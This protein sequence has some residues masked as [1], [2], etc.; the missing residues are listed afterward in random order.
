[1]R[2]FK[3]YLI[4][5]SLLFLFSCSRISLL[6]I[7]LTPSEKQSSRAPTTYD[8]RQQFKQVTTHPELD[9]MPALSPDGKWI[10][11]ASKRSGNM[12]IWVKPVIG[13]RSIQVTF[14]QAD[15][16]YPCWAPN[17]K[18]IVFVSHR[19]DAA[20]D[21]WQLKIDTQ[22]DIFTTIG[23]PKKLTH[24]LGLDEAPA[25]SPSGKS[26]AF[27]SERDGERNIWLYN[28]GKKKSHQLTFRGGISPTWS[29][30]GKQ[31]AF[32]S[33]R[34]GKSS[35]GD[36]F[37]INVPSAKKH[38][39]ITQITQKVFP[40]THGTSLD[41]QPYWS[42]IEDE[43]I[44]TRYFRDTNGDGKVSPDDQSSLW[45][46][47]VP[48]TAEIQLTPYGNYDYFPFWGKDDQ[49]YYVSDKSGNRDIWSISSDGPIPRHERGFLQYQF[50]ELYF[51]LP[52]DV[53]IF[54][55][56]NTS[57]DEL[58]SLTSFKNKYDTIDREF[59]YLRLLAYQRVAD[60]F[61]GD[62]TWVGFA[63]YELA[64]TFGELNDVK[65]AAEF[66]AQ[67]L[68]TYKHR[69][70]IVGNA[71]WDLLK[72]EI[73]SHQNDF[74]YLEEKIRNCHQARNKFYFDKKLSAKFDLMIADVF[75]FM[76]QKL[77]AL[78][79]YE[80][81][82]KI[83]PEEREYCAIAQAKIAEIYTSFG[84][85]EDVIKSFLKVINNY[86]EQEKWVNE[87]IEKIL[88]L[89]KEEDAYSTIAVY[90]NII[91]KYSKDYPRLAA[92]AYL[93]IGQLLI[94]QK[95]YQAAI[96][97]LLLVKKNYP[98]QYTEIALAELLISEAYLQNSEELMAINNLKAIIKNSGHVESGLYVVIAKEQLIDIYLTSGRR[99]RNKGDFQLAY[100]RYHGVTELQPRNIEA[101]RGLVFCLSRM[102]R[103]HDAVVTY[104]QNYTQNPDDEV[105]QYIL[106]LCYSYKATEKSERERKI[107]VLDYSLIKKS[108]QIIEDALVKN[109][110]LIPAYLALSYNYEVIEKYESYQ[111]N[112]PKGFFTELTQTIAAPVVSVF[113]F[114]TFPKA[115]PS[116]RWYEKAIDALT[117][118][119]ALNDEN[120]DPSLE[121]NL[122]LNLAHNYYNLEEF[123]YEKA[124]HYYHVK[125]KYDTTFIDLKDKAE[126]Y[127]RMGHCAL[128]LEDFEKGPEYL[129]KA[130]KLYQD[131]DE[132]KQDLD[133]QVLLNI[134]RLALL[135]QSTEKIKDK[136]KREHENAIE[137]FRLAEQK[138]KDF[139]KT[140]KENRTNEIEQIYRGIAYNYQLLEDEEEALRYAE[141]AV[142]L[143][144]SK[145]LREIEAKPNWIKLSILGIEFPVWN[146]G[147][148]GAGESTAIEGFTTDEERALVYSIMANAYVQQK[149]F[150]MALKYYDKKLDIYHKRDDRVA[151][152]IFLNN[153]GYLHYKNEDYAQA[154]NYFEKSLRICKKED[155]T[156]GVLSNVINLGSLGVLFS[157]MN[158]DKIDYFSNCLTY[159]NYGLALYAE[160]ELGF[161]EEHVHLL[162]LLGNLY[163]L[164]Q[165]MLPDSIKQS[166][167]YK[168]TGYTQELEN[169]SEAL[170]FYNK[171]LKLAEDKNYQ[172][173]QVIIFQNLGQVYLSADEL[174]QSYV[175][176]NK[177]RT[178]AI[179][180]N[181]TD[182]LWRTNLAMAKL[183]SL[184][185]YDQRSN[186]KENEADFYYKEAI[187]IL[188]KST[189]GKE[190]FTPTQFYLQEIRNL[191]ES[192]IQY[193]ILSQPQYALMLSERMR[194]KEY[195]DVFNYHK[196]EL[197]REMH[198]LHLGNVR[199]DNK[200]IAE[201]DEEIRFAKLN[202]DTKKSKI[203]TLIKQRQK[204]LEEYAITLR[205]M[206]KDDDLEIES[207]VLVNP[208]SVLEIQQILPK[209]GIAINYLITKDSTYVWIITNRI[210]NF[211]I[212]PIGK[213]FLENEVHSFLSGVNN[214]QVINSAQSLYNILISPIAELI[215]QYQTIFIIPDG[216]LSFVPFNSLLKLFLNSEIPDQA[217]VIAPSL[218]DYYFRFQK[219]KISGEKILLVN[220]DS[221][222][223]YLES[224]G[225]V[226][227]FLETK[228][229]EKNIKIKQQFEDGEI[230]H[231]K[232][233]VD[234]NPADPLLT[235]I[236]TNKINP[237]V[238]KDIYA[239]DLKTSLIIINGD[240]FQHYPDEANFRCFNRTFFYAGTPT[241][242][243]SLWPVDE[244]NENKFY[245]YFYDYLLDYSPA[246]AFSLTQ[247]AMKNDGISFVDWAGYQLVG[248]QGMTDSEEKQFAAEKFIAEVEYGNNYD[249]NKDWDSAI[250]KYESALIMARKLGNN[251]H[252]NNLQ[253]FIIMAAGNGANYSK[254]IEYQLELLAEAEYNLDI[255]GMAESY[256]NLVVFYTEDK[257][258]NKAVVYQNKYIKLAEKYGLKEEAAKS[259]HKLGLINEKGGNYQKAIEYYGKSIDAYRDINNLPGVAV[260]LKDRGRIYFSKLDN[261]SLAI[262]DI[263]QALTI[264]QQ[265]GDDENTIEVFQ[266][267]GLCYE[268]I[269]DY[270]T[271]LEYQNK[272][273]QLAEEI[274]SVTQIAI[275]YQYLA[276][277]KWNLDEYQA[278]DQFQN[279]ALQQF[280][281]IGN[282]KWLL[283][284][285][286]T[287]GLIRMS[288]GQYDEGLNSESKAL[289]LAEQIDDKQDQATI[290]K[291]IGLLYKADNR[292]TQ[293][294]PEF[295]KAMEIDKEINYKRGL[296]WDY[297]NLGS[298]H[299]S[300]NKPDTSLLF[301]RQALTLSREIN[302]SRNEIKCYYE[303]GKAYFVLNK[304]KPA[305]D[306]LTL[307][308]DKAHYLLIPNVEWRALWV[309]GQ[310]YEKSDQL[311]LAVENYRKAIAVIEKMRSRIKVEELKSGFIDDKLD[312]YS[313]L[314]ML[315]LRM[316]QPGA[317]LEVVERSK[318]RNFLDMLANR[319][320]TF[321]GE[322]SDQL[323]AEGRDIQKN[324]MKIQ[325]EIANLRSKQDQL[326]VPEK[327][328]LA[329]LEEKETGLKQQYSSYLIKLKTEN[330]ELAEMIN[331]EPRNLE[332]IQK[333]L[334][335]TVALVEYYY[336]KEKIAIFVVTR[337]DVNF[338][339]I[340][341]PDSVLV[342]LV[343]DFR[344]S[345]GK[346]LSI[347]ALSLKVNNLL[348]APISDDISNVSH[349]VIV[350]HNVLHY[351][352]FA[353]LMDKGG[354][355][356]IEKHT[357][358]LAPSATVLGFCVEKGE[359]YQIDKKEEYK[360][361]AFGNPNLKTPGMALPFAE[362]E[363]AS[364][365]LTYTKVTSY[366]EQEATET[367]FKDTSSRANVILLSCHG[368]FEAENPL[369]SALLLTPDDMNDGRLEAHEIFGLDLDS[370]LTAMS[371]C[372]TGLG[373]IKGGDEVIGLSRS[374]IY[375]G[376]ASL[377]SSLWKVDDLATAVLIKRFFRY[378]KAQGHTR[379]AALREAQLIVKNEINNHPAFWAAF[380]ISG[381]FR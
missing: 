235:Q 259:Y 122:A 372:E 377:L 185:N 148:I 346:R 183:L 125:L 74:N 24:H 110:R 84:Q 1:M 35:G 2:H 341:Q 29:P 208:P 308:A 226:P 63:E 197:K 123:G 303:L 291:N 163:Y 23:K 39:T 269:A 237:I 8:S 112:K 115:K 107:S 358:S 73:K 225:Y 124:Y 344:E 353:A 16:L 323:L 230:I 92:S 167:E 98:E 140:E 90:F 245:S 57:I 145:N 295:L 343:E 118:A 296:A 320:I 326:T 7:S 146:L 56:S 158:F 62:S 286:S 139:E 307:A 131:L 33:F 260:N 246:Q 369:F 304:M 251:D 170:F 283:M 299:T 165:P 76:D 233:T 234:W 30:D 267:L 241:I 381:D 83:Y 120:K 322:A 263:T 195:I 199:H 78:D 257:N 43:I 268:K 305:L 211:K 116:E 32:V 128:V 243:Y 342:G 31:I 262:N 169:L 114:I 300:M 290:H 362:K 355:Y 41:A 46:I 12:D 176:F 28:V 155:L 227:F 55:E 161:Q 72:I 288:L 67:L 65:F 231:L 298:L 26:I 277:V 204:Y 70:K 379:A 347:D 261:Y 166:F 272:A 333:S 113:R 293:A 312:V 224:M 100:Q 340:N 86:P 366:L 210:I 95:D 357:I 216:K 213:I 61:P 133:K 274:G 160:K 52:E 134:K 335:D 108:N 180:Y 121:G 247:Q 17:G 136:D 14:H 36:I 69:K 327:T 339:T 282:K 106:G 314:I 238:I 153:I 171:A 59:L 143:L 82:I 105:A 10:T 162:I 19:E 137:Y 368:E 365:R 221:L 348:I 285:L 356:L 203:D 250:R 192:A 66:Y 354:K 181:F 271:S 188:E 270:Q 248:F 232:T 313:D 325:S 177:A 292:Q 77:S 156:A 244:Q 99:L 317:A 119:I 321:R 249:E 49:I 338:A 214:D 350:P 328:K 228:K 191:Y 316:H 201:K 21:L 361:L 349:L 18:K 147:P 93:K 103:I 38:K 47:I 37:V 222:Y 329:D 276:N 242:L 374:F 159:I 363:V 324:I 13:G 75:F 378:L 258:F 94:Q 102:K 141:Q 184:L 302:D 144:K 359:K 275:T 218:S 178:L 265:E 252:V 11:F 223:Q 301:L 206:K 254:A 200:R 205:D 209:N 150:T 186:L 53:S 51:P 164:Q 126:V 104:K 88:Y 135:Y 315:L 330:A 229:K 68:K 336:T 129:K 96:K 331:V 264:F 311:N 44:F 151:E 189:I 284:G 309:K 266:N 193:Y 219:R 27:T 310:I 367:L 360:I 337:S 130:I 60:Y 22:D 34:N 5:L 175:Y 157:K 207:M 187:A 111:R 9:L 87:S 149:K 198:K 318:S 154:W 352:P 371:A 236:K 174:L 373:A 281:K 212:L 190:N 172:K 20:G 240:I 297:L 319:D 85:Y 376:S 280:E 294:L 3:S 253:N 50:A 375:A 6:D 138:E 289:K 58:S 182:M 40:L 79:I 345:I 54:Y 334:P 215:K 132:D 4:F 287:Q 42:P 48:D 97:E 81:L 239:F 351:L 101:H 71:Y 109:Y 142:E 152:A 217:V 255:Q 380:N 364:I 89:V 278:A 194:A 168:I 256:A 25:F 220:S 64:R 202:L 332:E 273:L 196:V 80:K 45:K 279:I 173:Q 117:T 91:A 15:D 306:S 370:Y 127:K 179:K